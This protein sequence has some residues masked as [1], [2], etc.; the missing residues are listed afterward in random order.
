VIR[1]TLFVIA[2]SLLVCGAVAAASK[3]RK[4]KTHTV[5]M[6]AM[7]FRPA[8][9]TV[10]AGDTIVWVNKDIVEHTATSAAAGFDSKMIRPGQSWKHTV[11]TSGDI[12]YVCSYHPAMTGTLRVK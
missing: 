8:E 7:V 10:S 11:R 5:V 4:S 12:A 9:L 1:R 6:E 2:L 3:H